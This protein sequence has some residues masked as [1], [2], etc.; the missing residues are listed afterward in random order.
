MPKR[1]SVFFS[2]RSLDVLG[3]PESLSGRLNQ[4]ID[5][6]DVLI[7]YARR[8]ALEQLT[9]V[10]RKA[11]KAALKSFQFGLHSA[12]EIAEAIATRAQDL[13]HEDKLPAGAEAL[14]DKLRVM[15]AAKRM[16][17]AEWIEHG[18]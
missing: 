9:P 14:P 6:Y 15:D 16:A 2:D 13:G 7:S 11:L 12:L 3:E 10:E 18:K 4:I 1:S 17:L 5:R 8:E